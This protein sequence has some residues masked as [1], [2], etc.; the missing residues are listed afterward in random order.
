VSGQPSIELEFLI[1]RQFRLITL[2]LEPATKLLYELDL[3]FHGPSLN[4]A[5][6]CVHIHGPPRNGKNWQSHTLRFKP[7][8]PRAL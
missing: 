3:V 6:H 4:F 8:C 7:I 2:I 5:E 1:V